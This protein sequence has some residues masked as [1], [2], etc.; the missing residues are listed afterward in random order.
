M[1]SI[2]IIT[3]NDTPCEV[4]SDPI[5]GQ[6]EELEGQTFDTLGTEAVAYVKANII[7]VQSTRIKGVNNI[8]LRNIWVVYKELESKSIKNIT[9]LCKHHAENSL[10]RKFSTNN[11]MIGYRRINSV[12][13]TD[14]LL[15]QTTLS[16]RGNR[17][18]KLY[19]SEKGFMIIYPMK[20]QS[21]FNDTLHCFYK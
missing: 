11:G 17:R 15:P 2:R 20:S 7:V 8:H 4:F 14:N 19:V 10:S 5:M 12:F 13:F 1:G 21:E 6:L 3:K 18:A 16:T 9:Q